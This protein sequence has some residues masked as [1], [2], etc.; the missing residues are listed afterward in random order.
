MFYHLHLHSIHDRKIS[1]LG[2][3]A[4]M[5]SHLIYMETD[6]F[7]GPFFP[8]LYVWLENELDDEEDHVDPH[9]DQYIQQLAMKVTR[10]C[11]ALC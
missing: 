11:Y 2:F 9:G 7:N 3:C 10:S 4:V 1:V 6:L 5:Q 8:L